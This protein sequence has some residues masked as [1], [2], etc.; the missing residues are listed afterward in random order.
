MRIP[1]AGFVIFFP[2]GSRF[3]EITE[4]SVKKVKGLLHRRPRKSLG[5]A[6]P[7]EAFFGKT[8]GENFAF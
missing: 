5:L 2:Q 3:E 6:T 7:I 8:F 4:R 1:M